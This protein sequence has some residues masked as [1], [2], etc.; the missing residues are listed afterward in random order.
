MPPFRDYA[1]A[2]AELTR[3]IAKMIG[4]FVDYDE[5]KSEAESLE[6]KLE[7]PVVASST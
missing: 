4:D 5:A 7:L 1:K 6:Q 3:K 2:N